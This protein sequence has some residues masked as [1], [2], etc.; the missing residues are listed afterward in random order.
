MIDA[1]GCQRKIALKIVDKNAGIMVN[2]RKSEEH[3]MSVHFYISSKKLRANELHDATRSHW[4]VES[5][6]A[7]RL[8]QGSNRRV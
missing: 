8:F 7:Q 1:M 5:M 4:G 6:L 3:D 2:M